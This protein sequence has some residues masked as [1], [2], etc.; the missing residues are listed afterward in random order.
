MNARVS[1][2]LVTTRVRTTRVLG[3]L[4]FLLIM[5]STWGVSP[6]PGIW[7]PWAT[8]G[9]KI[10]K[11]LN[12]VWTALLSGDRAAVMAHV[13][14]PA[15]PHFID[16]E[17]AR[18][19]MLKVKEYECRVRKVSFDPSS[20]VFA[21]V[22]LEIVA[23][24]ENGKKVRHRSLRTMEKVGDDWKMLVHVRKKKGKERRSGVAG[25]RGKRNN[26][27][28]ATGKISGTPAV[29]MPGKRRIDKK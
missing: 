1:T 5:G 8:E 24:L 23:T 9:D 4:V 7:L 11:S 26:Q 18:I 2:G 21:F 3:A 20:K 25:P 29:N 22:D 17:L 12:E 28:V 10:V 16:R 19:R 13:L 27:G 15:A 6:A 14:G